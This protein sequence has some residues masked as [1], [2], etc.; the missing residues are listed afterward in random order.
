MQISGSKPF[1]KATGVLMIKR[2]IYIKV[3]NLYNAV[4]SCSGYFCNSWGNTLF[5]LFTSILYKYIQFKG[6]RYRFDLL[7]CFTESSIPINLK[8]NTLWNI[9]FNSEPNVKL[10]NLLRKF[11]LFEFDVTRKTTK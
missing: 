3:R 5:I 2:R 1:Y 7:V 4:V 9:S 8:I 10:E 6:I 11:V